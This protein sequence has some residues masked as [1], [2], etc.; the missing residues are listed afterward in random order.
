M[1]HKKIT[2]PLI[3]YNTNQYNLFLTKLEMNNSVDSINVQIIHVN[4]ILSAANCLIHP[5]C[6]P[7]NGKKWTSSSNKLAI[8]FSLSINEPNELKLNSPEVI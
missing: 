3:Y 5:V 6:I 7:V 8:K 4:N 2:P 1:L